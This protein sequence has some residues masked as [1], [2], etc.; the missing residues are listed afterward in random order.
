MTLRSRLT[1]AA[2]ATVLVVGVAAADP[3]FHVTPLESGVR[4][5]I[6]GSYPGA[7]YSVSRASDPDREWRT[8]SNGDVLCI[9]AC[10]AYDMAVEPGRTYWYRFDLLTSAGAM[11]FGPYSMTIPVPPPI[12][13]SVTPNPGSGPVRIDLR[14]A[15]AAVVSRW[16]PGFAACRGTAGSTD[17]RRR[18]VCTCCA[19][20]PPT[21]ARPPSAW[22]ASASPLAHRRAERCAGCTT[23]GPGR[24]GCTIAAARR[25]RL[26]GSTG[27]LCYARYVPDRVSLRPHPRPM[28]LAPLPVP[29]TGPRRFGGSSFTMQRRT[30]DFREL[31]ER[32]LPLD[33]LPALE[34]LQVQRALDGNAAAA[35]EQAA[36]HALERLAGEGVLRRLATTDAGPGMV[37]RYQPP[38]GMAIITVELPQPVERDGVLAWPRASLPVGAATGIEQVRRLVRLDDP[39][40]LD[41]LLSRDTRTAQLQQLDLA[42]RELLRAQSVRFHASEPAGDPNAVANVLDP[43]LIAQAIASPAQLLFVPDVARNPRIAGEALRLGVGSLVVCAVP[44]GSGLPHGAIEVRAALAGYTPDD[45]ARVALLADAFGAV[46]DR[47]VRIERLAFVDR[48]TGSFNR[49]YFEVEAQNEIARATRDGASLALC[50]VDVDDFKTFNSAFGY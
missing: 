37:R 6:E 2:L 20:A 35:I 18:R 17:A 5:E 49:A 19:S 38:G 10:Y 29:G 43:V 7:Y 24:A 15:G 28:H 4:V 40:F 47:A 36:L 31:L 1:L 12:A 8:L 27:A 25:V 42:G 22:R 3:A 34:R 50:I 14:L 13:A 9:G 23:A 46:L 32:V 16:L 11:S 21:A 26:S 30:I 33:R 39:A 45:L 41:H 48:G 44:S